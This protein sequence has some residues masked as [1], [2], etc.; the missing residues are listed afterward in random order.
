MNCFIDTSAF[1][2]V[3]DADDTN[4]SH[5]SSAWIDLLREEETTLVTTNYVLIETLALLQHRIGLDAAATFQEEIK[6]VLHIE[7]IDEEL[8]DSG[9]AAVLTAQRRKLSLVDCISF[10]VMRRLGLHTVFT[11]DRHFAEQGF[12]IL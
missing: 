10:D 3:L 11:F 1:Y 7:W 8:H 2:A 4:H 5:A 12:Q 6:P 9:M